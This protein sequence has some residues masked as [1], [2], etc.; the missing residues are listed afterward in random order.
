MLRT[1]ILALAALASAAPLAAREAQ[2]TAIG[3]SPDVEDVAM[4]PL[5]DLNLAREELPAVLE[6]AA[7]DP[8]ASTGLTDCRAI[9]A[10]IADLDL[11]LGP[12]LDVSRVQGDRLSTG[13]IAKSVVASF[14]PFRGILRE[15]SG[16]ADQERALQS[17]IYAGAIRRGYLKG[18][19]EQ[20]GCAYPARPAFTRTVAAK[21][22][23][24]GSS[25]PGPTAVAVAEQT[26]FV[27]EPV[28]QAV[29]KR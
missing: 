7:V 5:N 22:V 17:A 16:A 20:K 24:R 25:D 21:P 11:T 14:I 27:S 19:G 23:P 9:E 8:Y 3:R 26:S 2:E 10:A 12:D 4:T 1:P 6:A 15:L 29:G 18:L 13:R 28:V